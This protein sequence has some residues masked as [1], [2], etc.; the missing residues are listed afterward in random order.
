MQRTID[1][2]EPQ[3]PYKSRLKL[4]EDSMMKSMATG[5]TFL[6]VGVSGCMGKGGWGVGVDE[7]GLTGQNGNICNTFKNVMLTLFIVGN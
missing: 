4:V 5:I 7:V 2:D 3:H 6:P 1:E